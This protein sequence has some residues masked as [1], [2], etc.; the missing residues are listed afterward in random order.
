MADVTIDWVRHAESVANWANNKASDSYTEKT[1]KAELK[2]EIQKFQA[3]EY[4]NLEEMKKSGKFPVINYV[5]DEIEKLYQH[6]TTDEN[7]EV[8]KNECKIPN[9]PKLTREQIINGEGKDAIGAIWAFGKRDVV[10]NGCISRL[11]ELW[12]DKKGEVTEIKKKQYAYWLRNMITTNFLFQP[13]LTYVGMEQAKQLGEELTV[14]TGS[15]DLVISSATVRTLM[16]AYIALIHCIDSETSKIITIVPYTN[17]EEN[18][19]KFVLNEAG[20]H[21]FTN[22][23]LHPNDIIS[24]CDI[25]KTFLDKEYDSSDKE[26]TFNPDNYIKLCEGKEENVI[27]DI[28][29]CDIKKFWNYVNTTSLFQGKQN[30]LSFCHGFAIDKARAAVGINVKEIYYLKK[31]EPKIDV[32]G[33]IQFETWGAN[34]SVFRH[35]YIDNKPVRLNG[36]IE[37]N[38]YKSIEKPTD[39]ELKN[40]Y[41]DFG[42]IYIPKKR[43]ND[44]FLREDTIEYDD[45][46]IK[47][48][49]G[50]MELHEG[51]LRYDI[52]K[53]THGFQYCQQ[54]GYFKD[55]NNDTKW[56]LLKN[57]PS[58]ISY[59]LPECINIKK[60]NIKKKKKIE[61]VVES[62][63]VDEPEQEG[64]GEEQE[65]E[66]GRRTRRRKGK[67]TRKG[68]K[69]KK[70]RK[71]RKG[72][73]HKK[74]KKH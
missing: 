24:V 59:K 51:S 73:K 12:P 47:N 54:R 44:T 36:N 18:D 25:I 37:L 21:D 50:V 7:D 61:E 52:A 60:T 23:A 57:K 16:T 3:L 14:K 55:I 45:E 9:F 33:K 56:T 15:H 43:R 5:Y 8:L 41:S 65:Q 4:M 29:R 64:E 49:K 32:Y 67:K 13:T 74:T 70:G 27:D 34:T 48:N 69:G 53:I 72:R 40:S 38:K 17:E 1:I 58:D 66:A 35:K 31:E 42:L 68:K 22:A 62:A 10:N 26:I 19:T 2:D 39:E 71:T 46:R 30:V 28:R 63:E 6:L 11:D 20:L